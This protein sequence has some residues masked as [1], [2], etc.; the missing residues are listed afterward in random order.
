VLVIL[1]CE[2]LGGRL[3]DALPGAVAIELAHAASLDLD[4]IID[5]DVIRRGRLTEWVRKGIAKTVLSSHALVATAMEIVRKHYSIDALNWIVETYK[6]M[7]KGEIMDLEEMS[8]YEAV[9]AAKTASLYAAAAV[10]GA[11]AA[12]KQEYKQLAR[13]YGFNVGM[14]FQIADDIVDTI[15]L[16]NDLNFKQLLDPS[17]LAFIAYI[18]LEAIVK[19]PLNIIVHGISHVKTMAK[20]LALKKLDAYIRKAQGYANQFPDSQYKQV[21]VEYPTL[22]V[23][24]MLK[25]GGLL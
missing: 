20:E 19:N 25:E 14:A 3:E 17:T 16:I 2:A 9:I 6:R 4:D 21:L 5:F 12:K 24:L 10:L 8:M 7:V 15:K 11:V 18:G 1:V 23:E 13:G 22:A